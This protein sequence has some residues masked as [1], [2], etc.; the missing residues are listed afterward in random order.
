MPKPQTTRAAVRGHVDALPSGGYFWSKELPGNP[1]TARAETAKLAADPS[2]GVLRVAPGLY[3]K[4]DP[5]EAGEQRWP[6]PT[7]RTALIYAG[8]G[9]GLAGWSAV[10]DLCWSHQGTRRQSIAVVGRRLRPFHPTVKFVTRRNRRRER[11]TW[12]EVSVIEALALFERVEY[13]WDQCMRFV[14][15]GWSGTAIGG[16]VLRPAAIAW[17]AE[18][19][20]LVTPDMI[21]RIDRMEE[22]L[23]E[24]VYP[25][26]FVPAPD[27][28][29][30]A[31]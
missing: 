19:D 12:V 18:T 22:A 9:A 2:T 31:A 27:G 8:V 10:R 6:P 26:E 13:P 21:R 5:A 23:P 20:D 24:I 17:A 29:R 4:G 15:R 30:Q 16:T 1:S 28:G 7:E 3:W 14:A 25:D 11:L